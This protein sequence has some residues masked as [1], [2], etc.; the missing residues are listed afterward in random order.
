MTS[1]DKPKPSQANR[2]FANPNF[3]GAGMKNF[4]AHISRLRVA[5]AAFLLVA[6][7]ACGGGGGGAS[8]ATGGSDPG[9]TTNFVALEE[10]GIKSIEIFAKDAT[11]LQNQTSYS[12]IK[13]A[14]FDGK[15][16]ADIS[17]SVRDD[18]N[19]ISSKN[20]DGSTTI[21]TVTNGLSLG[22]KTYEIVATDAISKKQS[23]V[24][25]D[26]TIVKPADEQIFN[27]T[28]AGKNIS[29][30][31]QNITVSTNN[32]SSPAQL[33]ITSVKMPSGEKLIFEYPAN[34][35]ASNV[36]VTL[37]ASGLSIA[38][39]GVLGAK[40]DVANESIFQKALNT[41]KNAY[42]SFVQ[43]VI[44]NQI[45]LQ[46]YT[47]KSSR[48]SA[49]SE[50]IIFD[51]N[52][53]GQVIL[54][55][56]TVPFGGLLDGRYEGLEATNRYW[57]NNF[58]LPKLD[59]PWWEVLT[60][61]INLAKYQMTVEN[62]PAFELH[63][64]ITS[65]FDA[66]NWD[67][68][69]PVLFVHGFNKTVGGGAGTWNKF[70]QLALQTKLKTGNQLVPFEFHWSPQQSFRLAA[71]DLAFAINYIYSRSQKPVHIVAHSFGGVLSRVVLQGQSKTSTS[72]DGII[73]NNRIASL[74]TLGSPH[75]GISA[76]DITISG[77]QL[78]DGQFDGSLIPKCLSVTCFEMGKSID[79]NA[80]WK[81]DLGLT[82]DYANAGYLSAAL[83]KTE[84]RLPTLPIYQGIGMGVTESNG[85]Y[86]AS[87]G[88]HLISFAGQRF[89]P[90]STPNA[91][92]TPLLNAQKI[93]NATV[94]EVI[95]GLTPSLRPSSSV[96]STSLPT[97]RLGGYYHSDI[98][99]ISTIFW[100]REDKK[101]G[102]MAAPNYQC[103]TSVSCIHAGYLLFRQLQG[104]Q[105][106][107][108]NIKY[109]QENQQAGLK[110][111]IKTPNNWSTQ[112][113]ASIQAMLD[114]AATKNIISGKHINWA[115]LSDADRTT[116]LG[117]LSGIPDS[118]RVTTLKNGYTAQF[119][120]L[121]KY[122]KEDFWQ[123]NLSA[124]GQSIYG[125]GAL[126]DWLGVAGA[127]FKS[128][129]GAVQIA[130]P[131][132]AM[133]AEGT[134]DAL[135]INNDI[136]KIVENLKALDKFIKTISLATKCN[137]DKFSEYQTAMTALYAGQHT[138]K[139]LLA[140][141]GDMTNAA[142]IVDT[143]TGGISL[144]GDPQATTALQLMS[145][146]VVGVLGLLPDSQNLQRVKGG[147][148]LLGGWLDAFIIGKQM[149]ERGN[150]AFVADSNLFLDVS[151][152]LNNALMTE[153]T[154]VVLNAKSVE[155]YKAGFDSVVKFNSSNINAGTAF[156]IWLEGVPSNVGSVVWSVNGQSNQTANLAGGISGQIS[157]A[158][159]TPGTYTYT[160]SYYSGVNGTGTL[161][162]TQ[163]YVLVVCAAGQIKNAS[164][165]C[166]APTLP[167]PIITD[168]ADDY[169]ASKGT[170]VNNGSTDDATPTISGTVAALSNTQTLRVYSGTTL[171]GGATVNGT[172]W[173]YTPSTALPLGSHNFSAKVSSVDGIEGATSN[174]WA[175]NIMGVT[176]I[177]PSAAQVNVPTT[178][179]VSGGGLPLTAVLA[180]ADSTCQTPTARA[181]TGFSVVCTPL[182]TGSKVA[183]V[184]TDTQA[185]NGQVIDA[186]KTVT[187]STTGATTGKLPHSGVTSSQCYQAG[188][189]ALVACSSAGALALN[190]QQDGH[191]TA[192]DAMSYS[193]VS[194]NAGGSHPLTSCVKDNVTG[195]IWEGKEASG[196]RAGGNGYTNYDST[197]SAQ[198]WNGSAYINPTQAQIDA[199]TNSVGYKNYVN[200]IA[201]C[202]Y[203]DWRLPTT[204]ELQSIVDYSKPYPGPTVNTSYFL[205]T[206]GYAYWASSPYVGDTFYAWYVFFSYGG[207]SYYDFRGYGGYAVRLVRASQ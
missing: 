3:K 128:V 69:E 123:A 64:S 179:A 150:E 17:Y 15:S 192:I 156:F 121:S 112:Q 49:L 138:S 116:L 177:S 147:L 48:T 157:Y 146:T 58:S 2:F 51:D 163:T 164:G 190:N 136:A 27:L 133:I 111:S 193:A 100:S 159:N 75:S 152:R 83:S 198:Y 52:G 195:L 31:G 78:P 93:G 20:G 162:G 117:S 89:R 107:P 92:A 37:P 14:L 10:L 29:I 126:I 84:S 155:L 176:S 98:T 122:L 54:Q 50:N 34:V 26:V 180:L 77:I 149:A 160:I 45:N 109:T 21:K 108:S 67:G 85:Q 5:L 130:L 170:V 99:S 154:L 194:N 169:G 87:D 65:N 137:G 40:T 185:N 24:K 73:N 74:M 114:T 22:S 119:E 172:V 86:V 9:S 8:P 61:S 72:T 30:N 95:L 43:M 140:A 189:N 206:Q 135:P 204:D 81:Q 103:D 55:G 68:Y 12:L 13:T 153:R 199:A 106:N 202:G 35:A 143:L 200:S 115:K 158:F 181:A 142:L 110:L 39:S 7:V 38:A 151:K 188:S 173:S 41:F 53:L 42:S 97:G 25:G 197:T 23:L 178:F 66:F 56:N 11:L 175:V 120:S 207:V 168:I 102:L 18:F 124:L 129:Y 184:K 33:K 47:F 161:L 19:S 88:D 104:D 144:V 59:C 105:L 191:R 96:A 94:T 183:T 131:E 91:L 44:G 125:K 63:T 46:P 145:N 70:P 80:Q 139:N 171:L 4:A 182:S 166:V 141:T 101:M 174:T 1:K 82:G 203:T 134:T 60:C 148:N 205:N 16:Q 6:V 28:A 76:S 113:I 57:S 201:L 187:V 79:F 62:R 132:L 165:T 71:D 167:T 127:T 196:T 90:M 118:K 186:S 32:L 36:K